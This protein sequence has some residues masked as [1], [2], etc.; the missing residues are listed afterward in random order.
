ML[1]DEILHK[2]QGAYK[3]FF[4]F[5]SHTGHELPFITPDMQEVGFRFLTKNLLA[6]V[7]NES[8]GYCM[9]CKFNPARSHQRIHPEIVKLFVGRISKDNQIILDMVAASSRFN[10]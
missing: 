10:W 2:M 5:F 3:I 6:Q 1:K 9:H 7:K 8:R 4:S